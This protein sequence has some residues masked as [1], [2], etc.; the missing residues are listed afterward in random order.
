[1]A[2]GTIDELPIK[3]DLLTANPVYKPF[4]YPGPMMPG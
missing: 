1:M 4:R 3:F 2:D